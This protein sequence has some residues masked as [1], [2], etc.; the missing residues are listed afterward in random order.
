[1]A[2]K[3][4]WKG[5]KT[6]NRTVCKLD[7]SAT[8]VLILDVTLEPEDW[9]YL[10]HQVFATATM[11]YV[12][13]LRR[14]LSRDVIPFLKSMDRDALPDPTCAQDPP[15]VRPYIKM[16]GESQAPSPCLHSKWHTDLT[17][18]SRTSSWGSWRTSYDADFIRRDM[19]AAGS[20]PVALYL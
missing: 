3:V 15:V 18:V 2:Y 12:M 6:R 16:L 13:E 7:L 19:H 20:C 1:M 4:L 10:G 8:L 5:D 11:T 9:W 17:R 14:L